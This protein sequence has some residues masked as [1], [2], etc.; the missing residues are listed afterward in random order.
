[1]KTLYVLRHAKSS[2][3][4]PDLADRERPLAERGERDVERLAGHIDRAGIRPDVVLCSPARR[5]QATFHGVRR[6]LG[7]AQVHQ[8]DALYGASAPDVLDMLRRLPARVDSV[9]VIGHN[10]GLEDLVGLLAGAGDDTAMQQL[11]SKFPTG[12]LATL[13]LDVADWP[14]LAPEHGYLRQL[15]IPKELPR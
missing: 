1:M 10:P 14:S 9:M 7:H 11:Q 4:S 15:V 2:W 3:A 8:D 13:D 12:A 6:A 5:A